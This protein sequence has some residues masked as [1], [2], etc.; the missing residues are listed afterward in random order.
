M[1]GEFLCVLCPK[2][3]SI[4]A[5]FT[6]DKPPK[7]TSFTGASCIRGQEWIRQEI[8]HPL[9][10]IATSVPVKNGDMICASVRTDKPVALEKVMAVMAAIREQCPDAPLSIGDVLL[11]DPAGVDTRIIV[12]RNV[13]RA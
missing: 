3:C 4:D 5:E 12:T 7:L 13:K 6:G 1:T 8:E 11:V 10:T 9:R 2:G